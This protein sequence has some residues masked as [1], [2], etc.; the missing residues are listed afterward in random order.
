MVPG[1]LVLS[2]ALDAAP[3][4]GFH[5]HRHPVVQ[6]TVGLDGPITVALPDG[7]S[8]TSRV[9]V[10]ASGTRHALRSGGADTAVSVYLS[11]LTTAGRALSTLSR[12][13]SVWVPDN[14]ATANRIASLVSQAG[15]VQSAGRVAVHEVLAA[16]RHDDT[17]RRPVGLRP[18]RRALHS[19]ATSR[20]DVDLVSLAREVSLSP[21]YLG[22][23][24]TRHTGA[25]FTTTRKWLRLLV[26]VRHL[27][28]GSTITEAAHAA[29][30]AD[31]AHAHRV[32]RELAGLSPRDAVRALADA[33][34]DSFK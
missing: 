27:D 29:G 3:R 11:P 33:R 30:F 10:I 6:V 8:M 13:P 16:I 14:I 22:R 12:A 32:C 5:L 34:T 26:A 21:D 20:A 17:V 2:G 31:S 19:I 28:D 4:N 1:G 7:N 24:F 18:V 23:L 15:E 25:P 9:V